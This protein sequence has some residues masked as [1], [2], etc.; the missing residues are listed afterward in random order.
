MNLTGKGLLNWLWSICRHSIT[1]QKQHKLNQLMYPYPYPHHRS[2]QMETRH[3]SIPQWLDD[4]LPSKTIMIYIDWCI[5][6]LTGKGSTNHCSIDE[7]SLVPVLL[8]GQP[9]VFNCLRFLIT[10]CF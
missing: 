7:Q 2:L 9:Y 10:L 3:P 5:I 1:Q 8:S 6:G 4:P